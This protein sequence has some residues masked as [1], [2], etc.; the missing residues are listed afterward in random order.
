MRIFYHMALIQSET[1]SP[2]M[3]TGGW[4]FMLTAWAAILLLVAFTF[5]KILRNRGNKNR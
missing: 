3:T 4:V 2:E 1:I 5:S